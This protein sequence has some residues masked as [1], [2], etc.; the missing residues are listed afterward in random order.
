MQKGEE[1]KGVSP[2]SLFPHIITATTFPSLPPSSVAAVFRFVSLPSPSSSPRGVRKQANQKG[3]IRQCFTPKLLKNE[4]QLQR[5]SELFVHKPIFCPIP[6][7]LSLP[8]RRGPSGRKGRI[9]VAFTLGFAPSGGEEGERLS[10][11]SLLVA[12]RRRSREG[13][14]RGCQNTER[15]REEGKALLRRKGLLLRLLP[16]SCH[17]NPPSPSVSFRP[18]PPRASLPP[19]AIPSVAAREASGKERRRERKNK[20]AKE[21]FDGRAST[22]V[23]FIF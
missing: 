6:H 4:L 16:F 13:P 17:F 15:E 20:T 11:S 5:P 19:P 18:P 8:E 10:S 14:R 7:R 9:E 3:E 12:R 1:E 2:S 22:R 21:F 23:F